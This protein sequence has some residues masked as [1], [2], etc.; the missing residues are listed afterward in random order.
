[1]ICV[2]NGLLYYSRRW[3]AFIDV[4]EF[5][6]PAPRQS[7]HIPVKTKTSRYGALGAEVPEFDSNTMAARRM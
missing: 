3:M 1:M 4:D 7:I 6:D 5:I 2:T